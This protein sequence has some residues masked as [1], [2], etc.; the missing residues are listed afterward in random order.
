MNF[1]TLPSLSAS[2]LPSLPSLIVKRIIVV[3][4][5]AVSVIA[6]GDYAFRCDCEDDDRND[7]VNSRSV[8]LW[9]SGI[10]SSVSLL[11]TRH[12]DSR[13]HVWTRSNRLGAT[14]SCLAQWGRGLALQNFRRRV[15]LE[16]AMR[17]RPCTLLWG[18]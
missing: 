2:S 12:P 18:L 9:A 3:L 15:T 8:A 14:C 16:P 7:L 17:F 10:T 13:P 5:L 6:C 4:A 11:L 1:P